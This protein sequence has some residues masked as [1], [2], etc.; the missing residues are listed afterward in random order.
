MNY[1]ILDE[2]Q[3]Q[4]FIRMAADAANRNYMTLPKDISELTLCGK[5]IKKAELSPYSV[6]FRETENGDTGETIITGQ[7]LT[8]A[9][10]TI[11]P[12]VM[13]YNP[14]MA[15]NIAQE[16]ICKSMVDGIITQLTWRFV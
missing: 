9:R 7:V 12:E 15:R 3:Y 10:F 5:P 6:A 2:E 11:S 16:K 14:E 4:M 1:Y 13:L 8:K